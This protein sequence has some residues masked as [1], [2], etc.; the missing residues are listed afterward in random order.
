MF[1][2]LIFDNGMLDFLDIVSKNNKIALILLNGN[3]NL[4]CEEGNF[5]KRESSDSD[6]VSYLNKS[7]YDKVEDKWADCRTKIGIGRFVRKFLSKSAFEHYCITDQDVEKFVNLYKSFFSRDISKL[8]IVEGREILKYYL[9]ENYATAG[10]GKFGTLWNS[11]MRQS[12]RNKFLKLYSENPGI[13]MLVFFSEEG[14]VRA[15]AL[16]WEEVHEHG[17]KNSYKFMDRIYYLYDHDINFFKDWAK[18]NGYITKLEQNAKSESYFD[19]GGESAKMSLYVSLEKNDF[20]YYPYLDT[21]KYLNFSK[22]R[23][24]NSTS[25]NFDYTLIQSNGMLEREE[26]QE[27]E[28]DWDEDEQ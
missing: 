19:L 6:K 5:I 15:R 4:I 24:S 20:L 21:F 17:T 2:R 7:K 14:L 9:E 28:P 25:Y 16:L 13:K 10:G 1:D 26:E 22:S 23:I 27:P 8:K 3:G 12:E 11:C 18:D